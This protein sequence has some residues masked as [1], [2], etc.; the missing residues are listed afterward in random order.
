MTT[1]QAVRTLPAKWDGE[2]VRWDDLRLAGGSLHLHL[3]HTCQAC[4]HDGE[5]WTAGGRMLA[6]PTRAVRHWYIRLW[7]ERCRA[8]LVDVVHDH[9]AGES[10][11]LGPEDYGP[12]GSRAVVGALW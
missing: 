2:P 10:W 8:C 1:L 5:P 7:V 6:D 9:R 4:G 12:D 11:E 3:P